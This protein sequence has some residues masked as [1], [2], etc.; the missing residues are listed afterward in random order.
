[1]KRK[2][3]LILAM[4]LVTV[5]LAFYV[6]GQTPFNEKLQSTPTPMELRIQRLEIKISQLEKRIATLEHPSPK[7]MP[8]S[9]K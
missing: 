5:S 2:M 8:L 1:M 4:L 9:G 7:T 6:S 3:C